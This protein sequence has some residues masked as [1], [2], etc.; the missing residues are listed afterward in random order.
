MDFGFPKSGFWISEK[1]I[2]DFRKVDFGFLKSGFR[3]SENWI[4]GNQYRSGLT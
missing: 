1:W 4:C 2:L 3:I